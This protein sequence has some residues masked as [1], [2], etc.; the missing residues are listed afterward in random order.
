[1]V[2]TFPPAP[3]GMNYPLVDTTKLICSSVRSSTIVRSFLNI[4]TYHSVPFHL[5]SY[6]N[7]IA[8]L[9]MGRKLVG[10]TNLT[11]YFVQP[12]SDVWICSPRTYS[13]KVFWGLGAF[14][15]CWFTKRCFLN[16]QAQQLRLYVKFAGCLPTRKRL[17]ST[18]QTL[19]P[20]QFNHGLSSDIP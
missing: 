10:T 19:L 13:H 6:L 8:Y 5:G 3:D 11:C 16:T 17:L 4:C 2:Y 18:L 15:R 1:M 9:T 12:S 20:L 7:F 14:G